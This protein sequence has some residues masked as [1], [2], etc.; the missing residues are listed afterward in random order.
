MSWHAQCRDQREVLT[1]ETKSLPSGGRMRAAPA[2]P[3]MCRTMWRGRRPSARAASIWPSCT[4]SMP[5]RKILG[6][7]GRMADGQ[8]HDGTPGEVE[9]AHGQRG[10]QLASS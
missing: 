1:I 2:A 6:D 9:I 3:T 7:K 10:S 4:A 8:R 5:A